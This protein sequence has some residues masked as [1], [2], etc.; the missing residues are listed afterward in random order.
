MMVVSTSIIS[1]NP[2]RGRAGGSGRPVAHYAAGNKIASPSVQRRSPVAKLHRVG[3]PALEPTLGL[4]KDT[5][6][7]GAI[8]GTPARAKEAPETGAKSFTLDAG[9][10]VFWEGPRVERSSGETWSYR[11]DVAEPAYRLR[12]AIDH[13]EIGDVFN[14]RITTPQG[15]QLSMSPGTGLYSAESLI[16]DPGVGKWKVD[17]EAVDVTDSAFR[18]RAKLEARPPSLGVRSGP[19]LPNLQVLPPHDASFLFPLT[20]GSTDGAPTGVDLGGAEGCHPEEHIEDG[21]VRCLRFAFGVRNTGL[22]PMELVLGPGLPFQDRELFQRIH[23]VD[24]TYLERQAGRARYHKS[25]SHYH[26]DAAIGLRLFRVLDA[27]KGRIQAAGSMRTKGFAHREELLRD[28]ERFYPNWNP[29]GFGLRAGWADIYEWDR[30]GNHID[31]GL[32][33]DGLYVIRMWADPVK[34]ILESNEKDNLAYTYLKVDGD[35]VSILEAGRGKDPWDRCK[36]VVGLGGYPDP[37]IKK[38]RPSDCPPDSTT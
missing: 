30:P 20:N 4:T 5:S 9:G 25:H 19:V 26:H 22:G 7:L 29:F 17:V 33:G 37:K 21:A 2:P 28:W 8:E 16:E 1:G 34:W 14:V 31:F 38:A 18:M 10:S 11:I 15:E 24:N 35:E 13:P 6:L 12:I 36:I 3:Y 23:R 32:N 27:K